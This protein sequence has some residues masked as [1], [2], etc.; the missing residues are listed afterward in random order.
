M[1][2]KS[3]KGDSDCTTKHSDGKDF[4]K[5]H[6]SFNH[7]PSGSIT[8]PPRRADCGHWRRRPTFLMPR[9]SQQTLPERRKARVNRG[10]ESAPKGLGPL[11]QNET[12]IYSSVIDYHLGCRQALFIS[13]FD[14]RASQ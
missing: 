14:D 11:L 9:A 10:G 3:V 8:R 5:R 6:E 2:I 12:C 7:P 1:L 4:S 13:S